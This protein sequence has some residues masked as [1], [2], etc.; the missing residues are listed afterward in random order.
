[1]KIIAG[2]FLGLIL[3]VSSSAVMFTE[4]GTCICEPDVNRD[5]AVNITDILICRGAQ[6]TTHRDADVDNDGDVDA[7]DEQAIRNYFNCGTC[8]PCAAKS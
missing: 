7:A 1:M 3:G 2:S 8:A 4:G 5:G 6:G